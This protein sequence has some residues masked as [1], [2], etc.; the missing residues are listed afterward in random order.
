MLNWLD[1]NLRSAGHCFTRTQTHKWFIVIVIGMMIGQEH[2]GVTSVIREL[3][4]N[5]VHYHA[6]LHFFRSTALSLE[7]LLA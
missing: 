5:P 1:E 3:W 2:V 4:L 6:A 7:M